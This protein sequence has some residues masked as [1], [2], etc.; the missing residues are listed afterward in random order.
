[1]LAGWKQSSPQLRDAILDTLISRETWTGALLSSLEDTCT[2]A[3]EIGSAHRRRL[4]THR[5]VDLRRRAETVFA[6]GNGARQTVVES[7]RPALKS[8][9]D[10]DAG[11]AVSGKVSTSEER[12]AAA[13]E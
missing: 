13:A 12:A 3:A 8:P 2:P 6:G 11:A 9:G 1:M 7:Y 4:L 5:N 10:P